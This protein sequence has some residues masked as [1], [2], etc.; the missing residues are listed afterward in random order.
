LRHLRQ[1]LK[2]LEKATEIQERA[3]ARLIASIE[4]RGY[5]ARKLARLAHLNCIRKR[6]ASA[7]DARMEIEREIEGL[8][9]A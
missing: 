4:R 5:E 8:R 3:G 6:L 7:R 9:T 1:V 2:E